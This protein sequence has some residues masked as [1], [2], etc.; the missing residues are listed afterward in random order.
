ML[1]ALCV[2]HIVKS[3]FRSDLRLVLFVYIKILKA[4]DGGIWVGCC[5]YTSYC[6]M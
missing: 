6:G 3:S 4:D 5:L 2:N 1:G